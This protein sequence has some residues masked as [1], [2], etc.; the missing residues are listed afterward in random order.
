VNEN[1]LD[2]L[3]DDPADLLLGALERQIDRL[4]EAA[5]LD[6]HEQRAAQANLEIIANEPIGGWLPEEMP[7]APDYAGTMPGPPLPSEGASASRPWAEP[8]L[9]HPMGGGS[10][11]ARSRPWHLSSARAKPFTIRTASRAVFCMAERRVV[12]KSYC[13]E[14][15]CENW[16]R[17][18]GG[19]GW[20]GYGC[21]LLAELENAAE[22]LDE[23]DDSEDERDEIEAE[24]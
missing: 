19:H 20:R 7:T 9:Y 16:R 22:P 15:R 13:R 6:F 23:S 17:N 4:G 14:S 3:I 24:E 5:E 21:R 11:P 18:A 8:G 1:G 10:R 12:H 2:D